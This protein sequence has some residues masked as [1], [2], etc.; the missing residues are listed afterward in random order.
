MSRDAEF[1]K[2]DAISTEVMNASLCWANLA[3]YCTSRACDKHPLIGIHVRTV[4]MPSKKK[5]DT[6]GN[7]TRGHM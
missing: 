7:K 4:V 2:L 3:Q 5:G 6:R 1:G